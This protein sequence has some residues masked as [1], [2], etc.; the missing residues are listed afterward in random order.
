[1]YKMRIESITSGVYEAV[2]FS[3]RALGIEVMFFLLSYMWSAICKTKTAA[4]CASLLCFFA[5]YIMGIFP[6]V[7]E[8]LWITVYFSPYHY[9][10][11]ASIGWIKPTAAVFIALVSLIVGAVVYNRSQFY[12][13]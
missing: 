5:T 13:I 3:L 6:Q 12:E 10:F 9:A 8:N 7:V 2:S 1:M 11:D 4:I